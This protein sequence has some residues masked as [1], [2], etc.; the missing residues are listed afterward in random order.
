MDL[1]KIK[2]ALV[3]V[4]D[5]T[6]I[7][8]FCRAL[9]DDSASRSSPPAARRRRSPTPASRSRPIDD[10]T[11]FPEMMDG[12]VKTLHPRVHGGLLARR[13]EP[14]HMAQA[15]EHGIGMIDM[16][17]VN[18]YP[19]EATVAK[20]DVTVGRGDR[21]HR[22]RRAVDAALARRR[23][24]RRSRSS[25]TPPLRRRS[26]PRCARTT[27]RPRSRRAGALRD[28]R[29]SAR[30]ARTTARSARTCRAPARRRSRPRLRFRLREGAGPALRREP[31][32]AGG[33]LPLRRRAGAHARARRAAARQGALATTTSST[34]TRPGPPC[35][36]S[37]SRR[38][39][40]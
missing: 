23:T 24:S 1:V 36:S 15:E 6:G 8:E 35:A 13:D 40:S 22:H 18:L 17:V 7:V 4:S 34:P 31:A 14:E 10:L 5:K 26:S 19:F 30:R 2:R 11:G 33:V 32:P 28:A 27:A 37:T 38:A 9:A 3:S 39:S 29:S 25:P 16:V 21:E 20:P 12:R